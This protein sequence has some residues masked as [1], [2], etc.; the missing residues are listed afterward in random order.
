[1]AGS[2]ASAFRFSRLPQQW[3]PPSASTLAGLA[4]ESAT[5][6]LEAE[7]EAYDQLWVIRAAPPAQL[8]RGAVFKPSPLAKPTPGEIRGAAKKFGK[9]T[10]KHKADGVAMRQF[11]L[12]PDAGLEALADFMFMTEGL[13]AFPFH[14]QT[15]LITLIPREKGGSRS[16]GIDPGYYRIWAA[17]RP[18]NAKQWET[19]IFMSHFVAKGVSAPD[20]VW[21]LMLFN[22]FAKNKGSVV[23][24]VVN[25]FSK[26]DERIPH[27]VLE[28]RARKTGFPETNA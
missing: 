12:V 8:G 14:V 6:I 22:S 27:T 5:D 9:K 11:L 15:V 26:F 7:Q 17:T 10:F 21:R 4:C 19:E 16:I 23:T 28:E 2:A 24:Q 13:G 3:A 1:M 25:E 18:E 20:V